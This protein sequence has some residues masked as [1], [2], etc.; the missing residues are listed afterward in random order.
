MDDETDSEQLN[1][2]RD[3]VIDEIEELATQQQIDFRAS[4][5]NQS[6]VSGMTPGTREKSRSLIPNFGIGRFNS[7]VPTDALAHNKN[8]SNDYS[9]SGSRQQSVVQANDQMLNLP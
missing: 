4:V 7:V 5:N 3:P 2:R 1:S 6:M 9:M 8:S